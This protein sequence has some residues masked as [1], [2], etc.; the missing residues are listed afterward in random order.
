MARNDIVLTVAL[1]DKGLQ[2]GLKKIAQTTDK[3]T[4]Q[5]NKLISAQ[6]KFNQSQK[7]LDTQKEKSA[8]IERKLID[9]AEKQKIQM[10]N[11]A[12]LERL[13][14]NDKKNKILLAE[15]EAQINEKNALDL[16][17]QK[18]KEK[19]ATIKANDA[20][21][22][23]I[24]ALKQEEI[25]RKKVMSALKQ[26]IIVRNK[27]IEKQK[28]MLRN[29]R[30]VNTSFAT[31]RSHLLL[32]SF[33]LG[34]A[35][36]TVG[37]FVKEASDAEEIQNQVNEVFKSQAPIITKWAQALGGSVGRAESDLLGMAAS[38]QD[39]LV[40]LGIS[41]K[42]ATE[43]S[44]SLTQL[45]LDVASFKNVS[46][47]DVINK[48]SSALVGNH[49]AVKS[50]GIS[51]NETTLRQEALRM[52]LTNTNRPLTEQEKI[53]ARISLLYSGSKDAIGDLERTQE[54]YAN[55]VKRLNSEFTVLK[56]NLGEV[57]MPLARATVK[58]LTHFAQT[59]TIKAY[60]TALIAV[61]SVYAFIQRKA[62]AAAVANGVFA[63]S[64]KRTG[65][66][67]AIAGLAE[68]ALK[69]MDTEDVTKTYE[70][71]LQEVN[72]QIKD[73]SEGFRM[74][75]SDMKGNFL[76]GATLVQQLDRRA[77]AEAKLKNIRR[78]IDKE[79]KRFTENDLSRQEAINLA[80]LQAEEGEITSAERDEKIRAAK[81]AFG[82]TEEEII[83]KRL[84]LLMDEDAAERTILGMKRANINATLAAL[85]GLA[86]ASRSIGE[87]VK[88]NAKEMATIEVIMSLI[89]AYGSFLKT[90][91]S[92]MMLDN[93]IAT[94]ILAYSNLA[95]GIAAA[96]VIAQQ[97]SKLGSSGSSPDQFA[98]GGYV[99]GRPHSQGGTIIEAERGEFVMSRNAVESIG[100]ETLNQMNQSGGGGGINVTVTGNVLTQDFVEGE[101]AES[102]KEA[103][104]RGSDFGLS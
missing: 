17:K 52:G 30:L 3:L 54:S 7:Q 46:D 87:M 67:L 37:K 12:D 78:D 27:H 83:R 68:L 36:Q 79:Q 43:Y 20:K 32:G 21:R 38:L 28:S 6:K 26:D 2:K 100:L 40:P 23:N 90:M 5:I 60:S 97:A 25:A 66:G 44:T 85:N 4:A 33:A 34:L 58:L 69:F 55:Q 74:S 91:N 49:E 10:Q 80:R 99:G 8:N 41:R 70:E 84:Q 45:A 24:L 39:V 98:E 92:D 63:K 11:Q 57:L 89:N 96:V 51:I 59:D 61:G 48:F 77:L 86:N 18:E 16:Q 88:A 15:K 104:R 76:I 29:Q 95:A 93:P 94:K 72:K 22:A 71:T 53:Q 35:A 19:I 50:L 47:A 75:S 13:A 56:Q 9:L 31:F 62:I 14:A 64:L 42:V 1:D 65:V 103:V 81:I 101:L 73:M 82:E 102:I